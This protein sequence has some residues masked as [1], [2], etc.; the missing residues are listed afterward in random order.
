MRAI[1]S[2]AILLISN[3]CI[4][5]S[6]HNTVP[7][8]TCKYSKNRCSGNQEGCSQC[9]P[10]AQEKEKEKKAREAEAKRK[11][12]AAAAAAK[13][14]TNA[15]N[16]ALAQQVDDYKKN[17]QSRDL[18]VTQDV[19]ATIN[20]P[21]KPKVVTTDPS[22]QVKMASAKLMDE[23]KPYASWKFLNEKDEVVAGDK[24]W[25]YAL[26]LWDLSYLYH[27]A[28]ENYG[29]V[30]I[31]QTEADHF[32]VQRCPAGAYGWQYY[33]NE[34]LVNAQGKRL[35]NNK[36]LYS[37]AH[38]KDDWVILGI[39]SSDIGTKRKWVDKLYNLS[40]G[41]YIPLPRKFTRGTLPQN[42]G[43]ADADYYDIKDHFIPIYPAR[44]RFYEYG[45]IQNY[46]RVVPAVKKRVMRRW[47]SKVTETL[48][49]KYALVFYCQE[50]TAG[51]FTYRIDENEDIFS[52]I[53][54]KTPYHE[55]M[56]VTYDGKVEWMQL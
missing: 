46:S 55:L 22:L 42:C 2:I 1:F 44:D 30:T 33:G 34:D 9:I 43:A 29:W 35:F 12:E 13:L 36:Y 50:A 19:A 18:L 38:V 39:D 53:F 25:A 24:S 27:A 21:E 3:Y 56:L 49:E 31:K 52:K 45:R 37:V 6:G 54:E 7:F 5:Q 15:A 32:P 17:H 41:Q 51:W 4:A 11:D 40:T 8:S 23:Y 14:K 26:P 48:L 16:K 28:P 47:P 10:C 20:K